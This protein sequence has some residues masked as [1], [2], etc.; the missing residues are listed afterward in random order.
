MIYNK[1]LSIVFVAL[2]FAVVGCDKDDDTPTTTPTKSSLLK[3]AE[4]YLLVKNIDGDSVYAIGYNVY[5]DSSIVAAK[6]TGPGNVNLTLTADG[7]DKRFK[8][9][10]S[11]DEYKEATPATGD[12]TFNVT[13]MSNTDEKK[14]EATDNLS[15][16]KLTI[17][18]IE[19]EE[20]DSNVQKQTTRW[21]E[22]PGAHGYRVKLFKKDGSLLFRSGVLATTIKGYRFGLETRGWQQEAKAEIG[23]TYTLE[24]SAIQFEKDYAKNSKKAYHVQCI[25]YIQKDIVWGGS[26]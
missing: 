16:D 12:F 24:V 23:T 7:T 21:S 1:L 22:V 3:P 20:Y 9:L 26:N 8:Y 14:E 18:E 19:S 11:A 25:S 13:L 15:T 5:S 6:V 2:L 17:V 10:P 4:A